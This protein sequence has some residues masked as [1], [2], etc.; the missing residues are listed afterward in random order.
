MGLPTSAQL[1]HMCALHAHVPQA[2]YRSMSSNNR[3]HRSCR[4]CNHYTHG[5]NEHFPG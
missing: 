4:L 3:R 5:A 2:I 1:L